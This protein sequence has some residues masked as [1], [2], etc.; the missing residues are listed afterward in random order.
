MAGDT[1]SMAA[2]DY[3]APA[4]LGHFSPT[5][6]FFCGVVIAMQCGN[7][8]LRVTA[9]CYAELAE[10]RRRGLALEPSV[11]FDCASHAAQA[12]EVGDGAANIYTVSMTDTL[13]K[14]FTNRGVNLFAKS[15]T[16]TFTR[17][18]CLLVLF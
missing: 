8:M 2:G 17:C 10:A 6:H 3:V 15:G 4:S 14:D 16:S 11:V 1:V 7:L 18:R 9:L 5:K 13:C 12:T